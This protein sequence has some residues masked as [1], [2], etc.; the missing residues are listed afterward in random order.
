[1]DGAGADYD[2]EALL[3]VVSS[4]DGDGLLAGVQDGEFGG[5]GLRRRRMLKHC[6]GGRIGEGGRGTY[7]GNF[8]LQ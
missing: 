3:R 8:T 5:F 4:D 7:L 6:I 1:M 2:E